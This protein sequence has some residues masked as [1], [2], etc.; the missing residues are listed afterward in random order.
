MEK[1][2]T[3]NMDAYPDIREAIDGLLQVVENTAPSFDIVR[4]LKKK[5][6]DDFQ[7]L[8]LKTDE[9]LQKVLHCSK[10]EIDQLL[11]DEEN[12]DFDKIIS[13]HIALLKCHI[14]KTQL[15]S[16]ERKDIKHYLNNA[17]EMKESIDSYFN[18]VIEIINGAS[19]PVFLATVTSSRGVN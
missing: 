7:E 2:E 17:E 3:I 13:L 19:R 15:F 1:I 11:S 14:N 16:K 10:V 5:I 9:Q 18:Q 4:R 12:E 6:A 8:E